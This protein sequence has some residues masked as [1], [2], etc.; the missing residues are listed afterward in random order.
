MYDSYEDWAFQ[1]DYGSG[2]GTEGV[3]SYLSSGGALP[4]STSG[5]DT[6]GSQGE[7]KGY[8]ESS[9][10]SGQDTENSG[11]SSA[12]LWGQYNESMLNRLPKPSGSGGGLSGFQSSLP[13][14]SGKTYQIGAPLGSQKSGSG[15]VSSN[16]YQ[17][18]SK[19]GYSGGSS[20]GYSSKTPV[21]SY[22]QAAIQDVNW[23]TYPT[24]SS[25]PG[26]SFTEKYD[27]PTYT[28]PAYDKSQVLAYAQEYAMPYISEFRNA[29]SKALAQTGASGNPILQRYALGEM[30]DETGQ[31]IAEGMRAAGSYGLN[32]Y[33][34]E[35]NRISDAGYK[36]YL[37]KADVAKTKFN[38]AKDT[39][40]AKYQ[41]DIEA[42][43][44]DQ[45]AKVDAYN[46]AFK[47]AMAEYQMK[48]Q[49]YG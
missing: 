15:G 10:I 1:Q 43:K 39:A 29:I 37:S 36:E 7:W 20:G 49:N 23:P 46:A 14:Y 25:A 5:E 18:P 41:A 6:W 17:Y 3:G 40:L 9:G 27:G 47:K 33:N 31:G 4:I 13:N 28:A 11:G 38:A 42:W 26:F 22:S 44:A 21:T 24:A 30:M 12:D 16:T 32:A 8:S 48:N 35:Y 19:S 34:Q 2:S 45:Q